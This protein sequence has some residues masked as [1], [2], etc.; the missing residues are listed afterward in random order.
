MVIRDIAPESPD[1]VPF[2]VVIQY[3][4]H[5]RGVLNFNVCADSSEVDGSLV[6]S[7][8]VGDAI[9][10][11][12]CA[13]VAGESSPLGQSWAF[14]L[15]RGWL[16]EATF[17]LSVCPR[18]PPPLP[19]G[20]LV[21]VFHLGPLVTESFR[22]YPEPLCPAWYPT[23]PR[24]QFEIPMFSILALAPGQVPPMRMRVPHN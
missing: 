5:A 15:Q 20:G 1:T 11:L 18:T 19:G 12:V 22:E 2:D 4:E 24:D 13:L 16:L 21:W 17:T 9:S 3:T 6:G 14:S 7:L 10:P 8:R 23:L